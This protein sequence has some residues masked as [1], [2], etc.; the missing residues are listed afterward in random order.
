MKAD[1]HVHST[2]S[3]DSN[4][5]AEQIVAQCQKVGIDCIAVTDH[6]TIAGALELKR[7]APF[8]VV[9]GSEIHSGDGEIIGYFLEKEIPKKLPAKE[10]VRLIKAQGGLVCIPHPFD[11]MRGSAIER[12]VLYEILPN[13]DIIE[14]FNARCLYSYQNNMARDFAAK[15]KLFASAGS[16]AHTLNEIG[17]TYVEMPDFTD[18][19]SFLKA[20]EQGKVT[21]H[22][23]PPWVHV[24]STWTKLRKK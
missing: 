21:G 9:V 8:R 18:K 20:L 12:H 1:L 22:A 6:N 11:D 17:R 13:I 15:Q 10:T 4:S 19:D 24:Q 2:Y 23:A 3:P 16:D 5:T 7:I 14:I